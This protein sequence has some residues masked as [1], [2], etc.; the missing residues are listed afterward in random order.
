MSS[1]D[2]NIQIWRDIAEIADSEQ[3]MKQLALYLKKL[4]A[5]KTDQTLMTE[6]EF[7]EK[8]EKGEKE[9]QEGKCTRLQPEETVTEMLRR[10]GYNV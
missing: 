5:K 2:L 8:L 1:Q 9:Y 4:I 10:S 7:L 6:E 3:L